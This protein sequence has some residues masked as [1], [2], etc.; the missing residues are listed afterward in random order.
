MRKISFSDLQ[1]FPKQAV[2][3]ALERSDAERPTVGIGSFDNSFDRPS[4]TL[5]QALSC[6]INPPSL[7][8]KNKKPVAKRNEAVIIRF[9]SD[10]LNAHLIAYARVTPV[11][12]F[13][14]KDGKIGFA[15]IPPCFKGCADFLFSYAGVS[16]AAECKDKKG[17]AEKDQILW[18]SRWE[19]Q[20]GVY[21][22][23][24]TPDQ[25]LEMIGRLVNRKKEIG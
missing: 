22:I 11:R 25:F 5:Q 23:I 19:K 9:I 13:T 20:G 10:W 8:S 21:K 16:V 6:G 4:G 3:K 14:G 12:I 1:H 15:A 24:R 17:D 18:K 7:T 2:K